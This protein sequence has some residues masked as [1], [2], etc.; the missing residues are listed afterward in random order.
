G[1]AI[2][3]F[4]VGR[5][6]V[7]I[8]APLTAN[9]GLSGGSAGSVSI[10]GFAG[11]TLASGYNISVNSV[12]GQGGSVFVSSPLG[13]VSIAKGTI[14][15]NGGGSS[16]DG[17]NISISGQFLNVTN[18]GILALKANASGTGNGGFVQVRT[19]DPNSDL[20]V[21]TANGNIT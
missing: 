4:S 2:S 18:N 21:G 16:G 7:V 6:P 17:G 10:L 11:I 20:T 12:D 5:S 14:N 9:S 13:T 15:A 8:A 1:G 3:I 19:L